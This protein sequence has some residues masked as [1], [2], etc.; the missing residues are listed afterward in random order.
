MHLALCPSLSQRPGINKGHATPVQCTCCHAHNCG[1]W[2]L[3]HAR[4][5]AATACHSAG[6]ANQPK[7][8]HT[9]TQVPHVSQSRAD[10]A[11]REGRGRRTRAVRPAGRT[12]KAAYP[13]RTPAPP[14][15][16]R[17]AA[18]AAAPAAACAASC[19]C[20]RAGTWHSWRNDQI[21]SPQKYMNLSIQGGPTCGCCIP[22]Q[23]TL[24]QHCKSTSH[25]K[26]TSSG[27]GA[28]RSPPF[29]RTGSYRYMA[30]KVPGQRASAR[31]AARPPPECPNARQPALPQHALLLPGIAGACVAHF[32]MHGRA[33]VACGSGP[34]VLAEH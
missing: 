3:Q 11:H 21:R 32:C 1:L 31:A 28:H 10:L 23:A 6:L 13:Q 29:N 14:R 18:A 9:H 12:R 33:A 17:T 7:F 16:R 4:R 27:T 2:T 30:A 25:P 26:T 24:L 19:P 15:A 5:Q 34:A 8:F 20:G 22:L